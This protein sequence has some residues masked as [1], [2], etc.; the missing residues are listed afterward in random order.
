MGPSAFNGFMA[1]WLP[2]NWVDWLVVV[3]A[4]TGILSGARRGFVLALGALAAAVGAVA[5]AA[6]M[7]PTVAAA[8]N[9]HWHADRQVSAFLQRYMPLPDGSGQIP[10]SATAMQLYLQQATAQ[11]TIAPQYAAALSTMLAQAGPPTGSTTLGAYVDGALAARIVDLGAFAA[12]LVIAETVLMAAVSLVFGGWARRGFLG[13]LNGILGAGLGLVER[14]VEVTAA[15]AL[16]ASLS[17]LPA[18]GGIAAALAHSRWAPILL[19][20]LRHILPASNPLIRS[21]LSWL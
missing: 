14:V 20:G 15:L 13:L 4:L 11:G 12:V 7:A 17:A 10:Y 6:H 21:W 5:L 1:P 2:V 8:A 19:G 18:F 9:A 16:L 3:G